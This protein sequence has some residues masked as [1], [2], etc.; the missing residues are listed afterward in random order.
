MILTHFLL[1]IFNIAD[2]VKDITF[3]SAVMHYDT[4]II[5]DY[6]GQKSRYQQYFDFNVF[7]VFL[8]SIGLL[9]ASHCITLV[10]WSMVS[11]KPGFLMLCQ[12]QSKVIKYMIY[13]AQLI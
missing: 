1:V 10:Y 4:N 12:H 13:L 7:Y 9:A 6:D 11:R 3:T 8:I 5:Q 2:F